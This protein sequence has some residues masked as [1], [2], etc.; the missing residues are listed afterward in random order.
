MH[1]V[2]VCL[3][4]CLLWR[5]ISFT[6]QFNDDLFVSSPAV[7][8]ESCMLRL[9]FIQTENTN[10][11]SILCIDLS[12]RI[13]LLSVWTLWYY[14]HLSY[15]Q[16]RWSGG[17]PACTGQFIK[18]EVTIHMAENGQRKKGEQRLLCFILVSTNC[19]RPLVFWRQQTWFRK[20]NN[21][22]NFLLW[23]L[24]SHW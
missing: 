20:Y 17:N 23:E 9:S 4:S 22:N 5:V 13:S 18:K 16:A 6:G 11:V 15:D 19:N 8:F 12:V 2:S 21:N 14:M 3:K 10:T 1:G 24:T 7:P